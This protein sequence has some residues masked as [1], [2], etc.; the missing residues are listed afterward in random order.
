MLQIIFRVFLNTK[1]YDTSIKNYNIRNKFDIK[2][3]IIFIN[4]GLGWW[5][6]AALIY[7]AGLKG[8]VNLIW[9]EQKKFKNLNRYRNFIQTC[10][11]KRWIKVQD[12]QMPLL[13]HFSFKRKNQWTWTE[14][15]LH[16][17]YFVCQHKTQGFK[18]GFWYLIIWD[19][20]QGLNQHDIN[21]N[22]KKI[23]MITTAVA[24]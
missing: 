17:F 21:I 24:S 1:G 9:L 19:Q 20:K 15:V 3:Y 16:L 7:L 10:K 2:K 13:V 6:D 5:K 4:N 8:L 11:Y 22:F 12:G 23:Y 18:W 14:S